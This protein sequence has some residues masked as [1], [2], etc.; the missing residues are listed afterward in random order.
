MN[1]W[2]L[3]SVGAVSTRVTKGTTPKLG[4]YT[5]RG[6]SFVKV[7][8]ITAEGQF[9][10]EKFAYINEETNQLLA[11]SILQEDDLLFSIAGT[12]GRVARVS[13]QFLPANTNQALAIIRPDKAKINVG[14]LLYCLRD[15]N[16][17]QDALSLVVQ[18]VQANLSLSELSSIQIPLPP[19]AE[20]QAIAE[21]LGALDDK[22]AANTKLAAAAEDLAVALLSSFKPT[23]HLD[24]IVG[25]HKN[26]T[27]PELL[28]DSIVAQ[29]SL[30]A[31]DSGQLPDES[32]PLDIKSSKF[33]I[34]RPSVL[35]SKLNPRFPRLWNVSQVPSIP[36][37]ASTEF[38][39]LEPLHSS[40]T[41]LWAILSQPG[42]S[43]ALESKV[44]GTSGSHQRVKPGDLLATLVLDPRAVPADIQDRVTSTGLVAADTRL[45]NANLAATRDA[46]LPQLMSGKLRVKDAET[47]VSAAV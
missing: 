2:L 31:F 20:Q 38:L 6:I 4:G 13:A 29:F 7:E 24:D 36:A 21:V 19:L 45:Q 10:P 25:Y 34:E 9:I 44:A 15:K 42:F 18:S 41:V 33:L 1:D 32:S 43:A 14:F 37:L 30:P 11:R 46:L 47:L 16:R 8:S 28:N 12:I 23:V 17:I 40:T 39:V 3:T 5:T 26:S 22:I 27:N 35:V